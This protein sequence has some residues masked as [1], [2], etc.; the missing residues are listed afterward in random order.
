MD[1][2]DTDYE[3]PADSSEDE[4][5]ISRAAAQRKRYRRTA[6]PPNVPP[7]KRR[8]GT[9]Q[10]KY[11]TLLNGEIADASTGVVR[12]PEDRRLGHTQVG[13]VVWT[14]A[15]KQAYFSALGRLGR[16]DLAGIASRIGTK[17][18]LEVRQ[19]TMLL[20]EADRTGLSEAERTQRAPRMT[21]IPAAA[22][23]STEL[24]LALE[25]AADDLSLRQE[26]REE[27]LEQKRWGPT[28]WL[29]TPS[30]VPA[31]EHQPASGEQHYHHRRE[32]FT[33]LF[34]LDQWLRLSARIF[35]NSAVV[36]DG[37]W[38]GI[39]TPADPPAIR[40]TALADFHAL[41]LSV[42]RRLVAAALFVAGSRVR[43][44][45]EGGGNRR[46]GVRAVVKA[47]DVQAA[48]ASV[49]LKENSREFW[50]R[51]PRRL[52]LDVY[53][54]CDS[55]SEASLGA[56]E[57]EEE[58]EGDDDVSGG[59]S[60]D[61]E[62]GDEVT[63][64]DELDVENHEAEEEQDALNQEDEMDNAYEPEIM[65]YDDVEAALG[66]PGLH[67]QPRIPSYRILPDV[68]D[69]S[70]ESDAADQDIDQPESEYVDS[71]VPMEAEEDDQDDIK[72]EA[73]VDPAIDPDLIAA[74]LAEAIQN[75][76]L[77]YVDT[78]RARQAMV[79]TIRAELQ[80][81]A[82]ADRLDSRTSVQEEVQLWALL[83]RG[84]SYEERGREGTPKTPGS[85]G[86][87]PG[88]DAEGDRG[89]DW[90]DHTEYYS[91]WEFNSRATGA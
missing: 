49:G 9:L 41:A 75:S 12:D 85:G 14:A 81:E 17:S 18:V 36:P 32:L 26:Q 8:K 76:S 51:A 16:D 56:D 45:Q 66:F 50:A 23:L 86:K 64:T 33:E 71:D 88:L 73:D 80:M 47:K 40:A 1:I 55:Q 63:Y 58:E 30:L 6:E 35:M 65:S 21:D 53:D 15:E 68:S 70:S 72:S 28:R 29:V 67:F 19:Y 2:E 46:R 31:L 37:N 84:D 5:L 10:P 7:L 39:S 3:P 22:E 91:D 83:R 74:D 57:E 48:V 44:K 11:V 77:Y 52:R 13:A 34:R 38:R 79:R 27:K 78:A 59:E 20:E 54:D 60:E 43:A 4:P 89:N 42:T 87:R 24:C 69:T 90:R 61:G 82:E 25:D 62:E